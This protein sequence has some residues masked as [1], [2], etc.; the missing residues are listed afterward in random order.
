M[1]LTE[2]AF[3]LRYIANEIFNIAESLSP[4]QDGTLLHTD[5]IDVTAVVAKSVLAALVQDNP[6]ATMLDYRN[7][8]VQKLDHLCGVEV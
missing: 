5:A 3:K 7:S 8:F 1:N 2:P 6:K 4:V